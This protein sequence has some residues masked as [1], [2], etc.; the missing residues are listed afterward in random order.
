V[1]ERANSDIR[2]AF[3]NDRKPSLYGVQYDQGGQP[4]RSR[5]MLKSSMNG[6][7]LVWLKDVSGD[8]FI[9]RPQIGLQL[10]GQGDEK[11]I[12]LRVQMPSENRCCSIRY[13]G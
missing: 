13:G 1:G 11:L 8:R 2:G 9:G 10:P 7:H 6:Q 3:R 4:R 5:A 12:G